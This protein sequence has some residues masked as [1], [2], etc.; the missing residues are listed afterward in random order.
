MA[1][2]LHG[3]PEELEQVGGRTKSCIEASGNPH[4]MV[5]PN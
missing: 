2:N 5:I 3:L 4:V 1:Q